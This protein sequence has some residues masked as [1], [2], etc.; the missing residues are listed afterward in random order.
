MAEVS[1]KDAM[2]LR[3]MTGAG[4]MD[5]KKALTASDGDFE[6]AIEFLREKGLATAA[7]KESR[8]AAEGVVDIMVDGKKTNKS[9]IR[10]DWTKTKST[11]CYKSS[12][13]AD[14]KKLI[15]N[16][17]AEH[18]M[19]SYSTDGIIPF[20]NILD[21]LSSKGKINIVSSEYTKYRGGKQALT[22][23]TKNVEFVILVDCTEE[24]KAVF[25]MAAEK[26]VVTSQVK[27]E[28]SLDE[29]KKFLIIFNILK[30]LKRICF[31]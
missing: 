2:E 26:K 22:T 19:I 27:D 3:K 12:A 1:A 25:D 21:I 18:L 15:D 11:F 16:I 23:K 5:C 13:E 28:Q 9:A 24:K 6:K 10:T 14:F 8:I 30:Y 29:I 17:N 31:N 20:D 4:V 7:K